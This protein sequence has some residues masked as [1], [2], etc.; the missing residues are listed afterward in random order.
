M[1]SS[2]LFRFWEAL[3]VLLLPLFAE[4]M[5]VPAI[6]GLPLILSRLEICY[7]DSVALGWLHGCYRTTTLNVPDGVLRTA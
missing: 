3:G 6:D 2:I 1:S 7:R 5:A 4:H